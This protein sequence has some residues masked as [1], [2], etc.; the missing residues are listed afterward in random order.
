MTPFALQL[1][2]A[3]ASCGLAQNEFSARIGYR[4]SYVSA[5]ECGNKL[6]KGDTFVESAIVALKMN[7]ADAEALRQAFHQSQPTDF[8]PPGTPTYAYD[9]C[10]TLSDV[11]PKL[12]QTDVA[13]LREFL[14]LLV[15]VHRTKT[16]PDCCPVQQAP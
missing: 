6:P 11:I 8:P 12:S 9:V 5:V 10:A 15:R 1:R 7:Q 3:R 4:Q 16:A 13:A 14:N 2:I